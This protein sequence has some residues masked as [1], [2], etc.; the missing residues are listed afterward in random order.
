VIVVACFCATRLSYAQAIGPTVEVPTTHNTDRNSAL[1]EIPTAQQN[2]ADSSSP[3]NLTTA[4]E[5]KSTKNVV[6]QEKPACLVNWYADV[7]YW[8]E[9]NFRGT[10]LIPDSDGAVFLN[11]DLSLGGFT[12]GA[13]YTHQFG[14]ARSPIW[15][16]GEG[17]GGGSFSSGDFSRTGPVFPE[18]I[19]DSFDEIDFFEQYHRKFGPIDVTVGNIVFLIYRHAETFVNAPDFVSLGPGGI[20]V[21]G[22]FATVQDER[23]DRVFIRL[24]T[25]VIPHIEPWI[26]YYQTIYSEG[27]DTFRHFAFKQEP[28]P[29]GFFIFYNAF[30][31]SPEEYGG[32]LEGRLRGNFAIGKWVDFNPYGVISYSFGDRSEPVT[33]PA[34]FEEVIRGRPLRGFNAAQVGVE[35]PIH[36]LHIVRNSSGPC[37]APDVT[38]NV[39]PFGTYSYHISE[40]TAGTDRNEFWGGAKVAITF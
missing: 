36:L 19:Q 22:P 6:E 34:N 21:Y 8:S 4:G 28:N 15:S 23:F 10:N 25:S 26:T 37:V 5:Y 9:Y 29:F 1:I 39:V 32:Y 27:S 12:I 18:T 17:G 38:L 3:S 33:H 7:G 40:P 11:A 31:R 2:V 16:I 35:L 20:G 24:A 13:F 30:E 14:T